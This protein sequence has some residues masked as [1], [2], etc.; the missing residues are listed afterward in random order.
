VRRASLFGRGVSDAIDGGRFSGG[1]WLLRTD[2][3]R[4]NGRAKEED[5]GEEEG[6]VIGIQY[7]GL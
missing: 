7:P 2:S 5:D 1:I 4:E 6:Y 3:T